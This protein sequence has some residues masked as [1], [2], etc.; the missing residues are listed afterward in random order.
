MP[1]TQAASLLYDT[2]L[3]LGKQV[4]ALHPQIAAYPADAQ[5][6]VLRW[7]WANG[8]NKPYRN[9]FAAM[10][11][12]D[13]QGAIAESHWINESDVTYNIMRRLLTNAGDVMTHDLDYSQVVFPGSVVQDVN[14]V[15]TGDPSVVNAGFEDGDFGDEDQGGTFTNPAG[16]QPSAQNTW[17]SHPGIND[18]GGWDPT[19]LGATNRAANAAAVSVVQG[20]AQAGQTNRQAQGVLGNVNDAVTQVK[21][22]ASDADVAARVGIAILF[23]MTA[24]KIVGD[25][26]K[27]RSGA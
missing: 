27:K 3:T 14:G 24:L 11:N 1:P 26:M 13:F 20:A 10:E 6:A 7:A 19:G 18:P 17:Q 8:P 4:E 23:G 22:Q 12:G 16:Q 25:Y 9:F 5:L 21:Q 2:M 15:Y